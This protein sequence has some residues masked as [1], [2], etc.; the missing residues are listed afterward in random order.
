[1]GLTLQRG[2]YYKWHVARK[3]SASKSASQGPHLY[4]TRALR[5][6]SIYAAVTLHHLECRLWFPVL[7]AASICMLPVTTAAHLWR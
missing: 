2:V 4:Q 3:L 5:I 7:C 6:W 1:M